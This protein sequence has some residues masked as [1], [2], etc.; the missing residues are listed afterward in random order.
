MT[1]AEKTKFRARVQWK[2]FRE[3]LIKTRGPKC[4]LCGIKKNAKDLDVH[5]LDPSDYFNLTESKFKILCTDCHA[6][7]ERS[8][9]RLGGR[10][11][12]PNRELFLAWAGEFVPTVERKYGFPVKSGN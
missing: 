11:P 9:L 8:A 2:R 1:G 10:E 5:H 12:F 3:N 7:I 6:Y 4:E